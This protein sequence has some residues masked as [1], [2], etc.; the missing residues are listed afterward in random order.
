M[1]VTLEISNFSNESPESKVFASAVLLNLNNLDAEATESLIQFINR[2]NSSVNPGGALSFKNLTGEQK[3]NLLERMHAYQEALRAQVDA[4]EARVR[5]R[6]KEAATNTWHIPE[7]N[8]T[9]A[10][11]FRM[12]DGLREP[13]RETIRFFMDRVNPKL[14][15]ML[16]AKKITPGQYNSV[17]RGYSMAILGQGLA[18]AFAEGARAKVANDLDSRAVPGAYGNLISL[19]EVLRHSGGYLRGSTNEN[20]ILGRLARR[21]EAYA[22]HT[23]LFMSLH[24]EDIQRNIGFADSMRDFYAGRINRE[25]LNKHIQHYL[26]LVENTVRSLPLVI[27]QT[28]QVLL[29][30]NG[31][32]A[33]WI[34]FVRSFSTTACYDGTTN[35]ISAAGGDIL[36]ELDNPA[37]ARDTMY[38]DLYIKLI[39]EGEAPQPIELKLTGVNRRDGTVPGFSDP[40]DAFIEILSSELPPILQMIQIPDL[41]G[42][43]NKNAEINAI[44]EDFKKR[45]TGQTLAGIG[46]S[47]TVIPALYRELGLVPGTLN[48]VYSDAEI[49]EALF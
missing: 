13:E 6:E 3:L 24:L 25:V 20:P 35:N 8:E 29:D 33:Q 36:S 46:I 21:V 16:R 42:P 49:L 5:A 1:G 12:P 44:N 17:L 14:L 22:F 32:D 48:C 31:T 47:P 11:E 28:F 15:D 4:R 37:A 40:L 19:D 7:L 10:I 30:R 45:F 34:K 2:F 23:S 43:T 41:R 27:S 26:S 18:P 9:P 39:G 38:K